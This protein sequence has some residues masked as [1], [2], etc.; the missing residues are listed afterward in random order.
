VSY[1]YCCYQEICR[2]CR[3]KQEKISGGTSKTDNPSQRNPK[4]MLARLGSVL[5]WLGCGLAA[6]LVIFF[7]FLV[8]SPSTAEVKFSPFL[9]AGALIVWL[10]GRACRYVLSGR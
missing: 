9:L 8:F 4:N 10:I 7:L 5:Y 3:N 6:L 1:V 2:G